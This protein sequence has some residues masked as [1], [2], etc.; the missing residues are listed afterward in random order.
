MEMF[1]DKA[2]EAKDYAKEKILKEINNT[3]WPQ[4]SYNKKTMPL[5]AALKAIDIYHN[6]FMMKLY[7][8][9]S[10]DEELKK[11]WSSSIADKLRELMGG[12]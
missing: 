5:L 9:K 2:N 6:W 7:D 12:D 10:A 4:L 11:I 3:S 8:G 1:I